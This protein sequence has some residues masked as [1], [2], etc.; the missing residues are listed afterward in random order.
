M[1]CAESDAQRN[2]EHT[3]TKQ[4]ARAGLSNDVQKPRYDLAPDDEHQGDKQNNLGNGEKDD[5]ANSEAKP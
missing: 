5:A 4:F 1:G 3:K 2:G